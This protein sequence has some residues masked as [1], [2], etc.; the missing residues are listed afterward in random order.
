MQPAGRRS[1][2]PSP[3]SPLTAPVSRGLFPVPRHL[4]GAGRTQTDGRVGFL[5]WL[6]RGMRPLGWGRHGNSGD[7]G[8]RSRV[9]GGQGN[10]LDVY[11]ALVPG[12]TSSGPLPPSPNLPKPELALAAARAGIAGLPLSA[13]RKLL[14]RTWSALLGTLMGF[15]AVPGNCLTLKGR[16]VG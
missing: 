13:R 14:L 15:S 5:P 1:P 11:T 2:A 8:P 4:A 12:L 3:P 10:F 16:L 9:R 7:L 6:R